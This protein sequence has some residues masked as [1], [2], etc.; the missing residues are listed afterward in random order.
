MSGKKFRAAA[1]KVDRNK[2]Y[3]ISE[4]FK[5]LKE[6]IELTKTKRFLLSLD[7]YESLPSDKQTI[8]RMLADALLLAVY[9]QAASDR[10][11]KL[12]SSFAKEEAPQLTPRE[13]EA[14]R[15]T[16][17]GKTSWEIGQILSLSENTANF[18]VKNA[19]RKLNAVSRRDAAVKAMSRGIL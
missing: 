9:A 16:M 8:I 12:E 5:L 17:A 4:G 2:R 6:T 14:L 19:V 13:I 18:H 11:F 1:E 7:R 15:W 10:L 3:P